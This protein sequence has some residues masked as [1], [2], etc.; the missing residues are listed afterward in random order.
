MILINVK[1]EVADFG[2]SFEK[3]VDLVELRRLLRDIDILEIKAVEMR[4]SWKTEGY[5]D[6]PGLIGAT[7]PDYQ[8]AQETCV[9][10]RSI[11]EFCH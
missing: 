10:G 9:E 8:D 7:T 11:E 3:R 5:A 6:Y 2:P 1:Y 4:K